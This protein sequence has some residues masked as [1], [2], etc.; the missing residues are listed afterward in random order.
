MARLAAHRTPRGVW[1]KPIL[2]TCTL[3]LSGCDAPA[4]PNGFLETWTTEPHYEFGD[5]D[6]TR[7]S[8]IVHL[9]ADGLSDRVLVADATAGEV[10]AWSTDGSLLFA[11]GRRGE[12]PGEFFDVPARI[13]VFPDG[14]FYVRDGSGRRFTYFDANGRLLRTVSGPPPEAVSWQ[15]F[16]IRP[17]AR[18]P[19][20]IFVGTPDIA[21]SIQAGFRGGEPI[22]ELPVL[23][24]APPVAGAWPMPSILLW[25]ND[26][27]GLLSVQHEHGAFFTGQPFSDDDQI[28]VDAARAT[29]IM[30]RRNGSPGVVELAEVTSSGDTLWDAQMDLPYRGFEADMKEIWIDR[31][32]PR[33]VGQGLSVREARTLIDNAL[34]APEHLAPVSHVVVVTPEAVW[35]K[36]NG[37]SEATDTLATWYR[38]TREP[39]SKL[40]R[41]LL[42][43][44]F[45]L[46]DATRSHVWGVRQDELGLPRIV[47]RRN[48]P[49]S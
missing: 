5:V 47:G 31:Y 2:A 10:T 34:H 48:V 13:Q 29:V 17:E 18:F 45:Q 16:R 38:V 44:R 33:L 30:L 28:R 3:V 20:G 9:D 32:A 8:Q 26:A 7:L 42:P 27:T 43:S 41:V 39:S 15:G 12:G 23:L 22:T 6:E 14:S 49:H 36:G 21:A 1:D 46:M 37:P 25:E 11:V 40:V 19:D 4:A 35:L 24:I